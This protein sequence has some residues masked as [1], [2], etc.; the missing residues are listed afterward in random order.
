[1]KINFRGNQ[2]V[3]KFGTGARPGEAL[4][5]EFVHRHAPPSSIPLPRVIGLWSSESTS[6]SEGKSSTIHYIVT[7]WVEN[8][9]TLEDVWPHLGSSSK[10]TIV[11]QLR[12]ILQT[13]R[14]LEPPDGVS[15]IGSAGRLPCADPI[16]RDKGPFDSIDA[17]NAGYL[18]VARP[19]FRGHHISVIER[20]LERIKQYRI[21]FTHGDLA[22]SNILVRTRT[23]GATSESEEWDVVALIDWECAGWYPEHWEYIKLLNCVK[24]K[25]DWAS[26]AQSLLER[27]YDDDFI[28]DSRLRLYYRI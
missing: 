11:F 6:A 27:H 10:E 16:I 21:V 28:L 7:E 19:C 3:V 2:A 23:L 18:E 4:A 1:M 5:M 15:Y 20:L 12:K 26:Y 13:L 22:L 24:W 25:S 8:A 9:E 14:Q 17:F